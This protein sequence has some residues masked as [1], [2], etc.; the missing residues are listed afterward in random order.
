MTDLLRELPENPVPEN[1]QAEMISAADGCRLR[2]A[3]FPSRAE[4]GTVVILPG[5]NECIEKY[6]ETVRDLSSRGFAAAALDWRGQGGSQ[7][8]LRNPMRGHVHDFDEYVADLNLFFR[9]VVLPDCPPPYTLLAHSTGA[10]IALLAGPELTNRVRRMVLLAPLLEIRAPI[11]MPAIGRVAG[12][13]NALG[14]G[15]AYFAGASRRGKEVPFE[16][17]RLTSD[18][19]RFARNQMLLRTFPELF[20]HGPTVAWMRA[21]CLAA[22]RVQQPKFMA[23]RRIPTLILAAGDDRVVSTPAI[24]RYARRLRAA[25]VLTVDGARHELLQEADIYRE[26]VLAAFEAFA[27]RHESDAL[28]FS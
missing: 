9:K 7:R 18:P 11:S 22:E 2:C 19:T 14:F 15:N 26:Q 5:R 3:R 10:L 28:A 6:F 25:K 20:I 21:V 27:H 8:L 4:N 13:L 17:N 23:K 24:E 1:A 12:F 16:P